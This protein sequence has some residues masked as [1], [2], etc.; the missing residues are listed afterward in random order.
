VLRELCTGS[1]AH[2]DRHDVAL[3]L[4]RRSRD[5]ALHERPLPRAPGAAEPDRQR[6]PPHRARRG[7]RHRPRRTS[8]ASLCKVSDTG[9]GIAA[10]DLPHVFAPFRTGA[11]GRTGSGLGLYIVKRFC[12]TLGGEVSV[13]ST[14]GA[15]TRFTVDLPVQPPQ[16]AL[17]SPLR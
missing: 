1:L 3:T 15:G 14:V 13:A 10:D 2:R 17:H 12:E 16:R 11:L 6:A 5:A 4:A 7:R 9:I 8:A